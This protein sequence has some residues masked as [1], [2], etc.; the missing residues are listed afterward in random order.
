MYERRREPLM[1][2]TRFMLRMAAHMVVA[3]MLLMISLAIGVWGFMSFDALAP[4][5]ALLNS[6]MLLTG[7]GPVSD[8]SSDA[9][10]LFATFY[11]GLIFLAAAGIFFAPI[12]HRFLHHFHLEM[13]EEDAAQ[14]AP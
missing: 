7:M 3:V 14:D 2:F 1:T 8:P 6:S 4:I 5:D 12:L 9:G 13:A 10:K 11:A